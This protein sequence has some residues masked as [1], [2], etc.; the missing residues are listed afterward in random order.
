METNLG[1]PLTVRFSSEQR[2]ELERRATESRT[3]MASVIRLAVA[4]FLAQNYTHCISNSTESEGK[5]S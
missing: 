3:D 4:I 2:R 5:A 1:K